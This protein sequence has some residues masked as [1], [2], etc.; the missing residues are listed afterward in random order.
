MTT[1]G[2]HDLGEECRCVSNHNPN[3]MELNRHHIWP[4]GMGGPDTSDNIEWLCPTTH[5][6][7]HELLRAYE[8]YE[9]DPPWE[10]R[11]HFSP[12]V[13]TLA[14]RGYILSREGEPS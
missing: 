14:A 7:V 3:P 1:Y 2:G 5:V 6:N 13:R 9:G 8:K 10:I 11:K 12:F 4:L